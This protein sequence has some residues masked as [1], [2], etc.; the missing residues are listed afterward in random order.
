MKKK[1]RKVWRTSASILPSRERVGARLDLNA[2]T[3]KESTTFYAAIPR[4][5]TMRAVDLLTDIVFD[6]IFPQ[7]EIEKEAEVVCDEIESYNDSPIELIYDEFENLLFQGHPLGHSILGQKTS[8]GLPRRMPCG[9]PA[10]T[11]VPTMPCSLPT[12]T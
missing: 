4:E 9:L 8:G 5:H 1:A 3:T 6:S 10:A 11:I 12:A 7:H 2:F